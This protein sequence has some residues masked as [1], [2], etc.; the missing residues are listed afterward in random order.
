MK[1]KKITLATI[2]SFA[3]ACLFVSFFSLTET[4]DAQVILPGGGQSDDEKE[5]ALRCISNPDIL[6]IY[7]TAGNSDCSPKDC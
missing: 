1:S 6:Q 5:N 2:V 7:C 4:V 3:G